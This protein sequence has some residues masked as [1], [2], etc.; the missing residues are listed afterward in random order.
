[1]IDCVDISSLSQVSSSLP[2]TEE[3]LQRILGLLEHY[4]TP[5][6]TQH[7]SV[8]SNLSSLIAEGSASRGGSDDDTGSTNEGSQVS[9]NNVD[10]LSSLQNFWKSGH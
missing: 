1:M 2:S 4:I 6:L 7:H 8:I 9:I 5:M 3:H 10:A